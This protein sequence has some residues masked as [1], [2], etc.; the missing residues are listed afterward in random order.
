MSGDVADV[1][2]R[3]RYRKKSHVVSFVVLDKLRCSGDECPINHVSVRLL[4][5]CPNLLVD[6]LAVLE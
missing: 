5:G 4:G 2:A 3:A 6:N 1:S